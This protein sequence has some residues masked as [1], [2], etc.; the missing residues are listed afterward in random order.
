MFHFLCCNL[1]FMFHCVFVFLIRFILIYFLIIICIC[2][3]FCNHFFFDSE[4]HAVSFF[5]LVLHFKETISER[6]R[7]D[8]LNLGY[9]LFIS[10]T[11]IES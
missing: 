5:T 2:N 7:Y 8:S 6:V 1:F 4:T 3:S 9:K 10:F 11:T